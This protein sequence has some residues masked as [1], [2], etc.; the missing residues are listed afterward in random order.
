MAI[1]KIVFKESAFKELQ[2]LDKAVRVRVSAVIDAL[3]YNPRPP[4]Y[5]KMKG[6]S[7]YR[8]RI[9]DWRVIYDVVDNILTV[10]ILKIGHRGGIYD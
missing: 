3:A 5:L 10:T 4:G 7:S 8:I 1:Y 9:G 2:S 6:S